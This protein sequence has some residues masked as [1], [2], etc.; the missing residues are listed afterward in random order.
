MKSYNDDTT[1]A[2]FFFGTLMPSFTYTHTSLFF[3]LSISSPNNVDSYFTRPENDI[4][5]RALLFSATAAAIETFFAFSFGLA[6]RKKKFFSSNL[7]RK[8]PEQSWICEAR[9]KRRRKE[10]YPLRK[11]GK[12]FLEKKE[13]S[14]QFWISDSVLAQSSCPLDIFCPF[15]AIR[16]YSIC[17]KWN[18]FSR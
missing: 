16:P 9:R 12:I 15:C 11:K 7:L 14:K 13:K 3:F 10:A 2:R 4:L 5:Q 1:S 6:E 18:I 8:R 17:R